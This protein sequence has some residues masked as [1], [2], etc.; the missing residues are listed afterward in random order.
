MSRISDK[1]KTGT[2][3]KPGWLTVDVKKHIMGGSSSVNSPSPPPAA[4]ETKTAINTPIVL[5][6]A[7]AAAAAP[8][9]TPADI[10]TVATEEITEPVVITVVPTPIAPT[11]SPS[12]DPRPPVVEPTTGLGTLNIYYGT[13]TG[14]AMG[15]ARLL[16]NE[17]KQQGFKASAIDLEDLDPTTLA[18]TSSSSL[19]IFVMA[20]AGEGNKQHCILSLT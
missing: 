20:T 12:P 19:S 10:P 3:T 2:I 11:V 7:A 6:V 17:G 16:A 13:A 4:I 1:N 18:T 9:V 5:P 8:I 15:F 14:T